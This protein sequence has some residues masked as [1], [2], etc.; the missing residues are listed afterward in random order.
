M[1][2]IQ[3]CS[4]QDIVRTNF[5]PGNR[6]SVECVADNRRD[7]SVG[8]A[9]AERVVM[10]FATSLRMPVA[11]ILNFPGARITASG[12]KAVEQCHPG[13]HD[14]RFATHTLRRSVNRVERQ[15]V[16]QALAFDRVRITVDLIGGVTAGDRKYSRRVIR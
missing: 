2:L 12:I 1:A 10:V 11:A 16:A 9:A 5:G 8:D 14:A 13:R 6:K 4:R 15:T 3:V 7:A